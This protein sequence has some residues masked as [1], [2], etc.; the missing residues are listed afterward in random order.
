MTLVG[1]PFR[2][3]QNKLFAPHT[4]Q[5]VRTEHFGGAPETVAPYMVHKTS[6]N[7][8]LCNLLISCTP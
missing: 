4:P 8:L 6:F 3:A 7:G 5:P 2:Y 1:I